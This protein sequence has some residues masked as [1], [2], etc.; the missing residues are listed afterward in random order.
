MAGHVDGV[1]LGGKHAPPG[2][3]CM[4]YLKILGWRFL[5]ES[6]TCPGFWTTKL[7]G[8][9]C[10]KCCAA[11]LPGLVTLSGPGTA[12]APDPA[13]VASQYPRTS[14]SDADSFMSCTREGAKFMA[15][16]HFW[17]KGLRTGELY[18]TVWTKNVIPP[19]H[20]APAWSCKE[21]L[22]FPLTLPKSKKSAVKKTG[23]PAGKVKTK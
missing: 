5:C 15:R 16:K 17:N 10:P 19:G 6:K 8:V 20:I 14:A 9:A 7:K 3:T 22:T 1:E 23:A 12:S 13:Y 2:Y 11:G 18:L 4:S 21:T